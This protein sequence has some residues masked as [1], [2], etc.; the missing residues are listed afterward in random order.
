MD[1]KDFVTHPI[2]N[3]YAADKQGN[4]IHLDHRVPTK[5]S[6][7]SSGYYIVMVRS[8]NNKKQKAILT[9]RFVWDCFKGVIPIDKVIDHINNNK[10]DNQ[11]ENLQLSPHKENCKKIC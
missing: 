8:K 10:Q 9:H 7:N 3:K 4:V 5:G 1:I 11:S 2:Y 6:L